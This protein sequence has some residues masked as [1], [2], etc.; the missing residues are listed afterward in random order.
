MH[1]SQEKSL[2][3]YEWERYGYSHLYSM[4]WE[5]IYPYNG[6]SMETS[7]PYLTV[8]DLQIQLYILLLDLVNLVF[9]KTYLREASLEN[10][11]GCHLQSV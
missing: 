10:V 8:C 3:I 11:G 9:L 5:K 7:F 2:K 1:Q 4:D 6:K